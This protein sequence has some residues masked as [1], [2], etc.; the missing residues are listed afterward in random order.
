MLRLPKFLPLLAS[1]GVI[2]KGRRRT[3]GTGV[4]L[5]AVTNFVPCANVEVPSENAN[6][7]DLTVQ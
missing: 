5:F 7:Q 1:E 2:A 4:C 3:G 6:A